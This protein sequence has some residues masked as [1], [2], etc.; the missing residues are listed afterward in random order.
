MSRLERYVQKFR[1][2]EIELE[3]A[4]YAL[5]KEP[6]FALEVNPSWLAT[7]PIR[8]IIVALQK[9]GSSMSRQTLRTYLKQHGHMKNEEI[10]D[11]V[12]RRIFKKK[13]GNSRAVNVALEQLIELYERR[14]IL[15]KLRDVVEDITSP[16]GFDIDKAK[17][18]LKELSIGVERKGKIISESYTDSFKKRLS[19]VKKRNEDGEGNGILTGIRA[20]DIMTGGLMIPEW[21]VIGGQPGVGKSATL[22]CLAV[23]A[24]RTGANVLFVSGEMPKE[25]I[26]FRMDSMLTGISSA[27]YRIGNLKDSELSKW[28]KVIEREEGLNNSFLEIASFPRGFTVSD[29][30]GLVSRIEDRYQ[31]KVDLICLDY[32]NIMTTRMGSGRYSNKDWQAQA[33]V[34]WEVKAMC[35]ELPVRLWTAGQLKDEAIDSPK[36]SLEHLKYSRAISETAPIVVGLVRTMDEDFEFSLEW[37][38]LKMRNTPVPSRPIILRPNLDVMRIHEEVI[39]KIKD[40]RYLESDFGQRHEEKKQKT[41]KRRYD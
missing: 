34:A 11:E 6:A 22:G 39:P 29:V 9:V 13:I 1:D 15:I 20:F 23:G 30:E 5:R 12:V 41:K 28:K 26:E 10:Y 21:G 2:E 25:D 24:W 14:Q 18:T 36:L 33:D 8:K 3:V 7:E 35:A 19:I 16:K 4:A 17:T 32:I 40:I 38:V 31:K 27:K 37:Q